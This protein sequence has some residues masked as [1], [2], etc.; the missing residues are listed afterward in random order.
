MSAAPQLSLTNIIDISAVQAAAGVGTYNTSNLCLFTNEAPSASTSA[1]TVATQ[2]VAFSDVAASG[3]FKLNY[4]GNVTASIAY[5]ASASTIQ[6][7][8]QALPGLGSVTVSG[9]IASRSLSVTFVG[10]YGA[11]P[12]LT[13]SS[14]TLE[15]GSSTAITTTVT[16]AVAGQT[17]AAY[18]TPTP[19]GTDFGSASKTA[20]MANAVFAQTPNILQGDGQFIV[21]LLQVATQNISLSGIAASGAFTISYGGNTTASIAWNATTAAIQADL[22]ALPGLASVVVAGSIASQ[23]LNIQFYGVYG[24]LSAVTMPTNTLETSGSVS[25]TPTITTPIVG[26]TLDAAITATTSAF[27]YFGIVT[28]TNLAEM[29]QANMLAA[30]AVVQALNKMVFF[31]TNAS[32][33]I[34]PGGSIDLLRSG[35]Y[36]QSRG[37]YYGDPSEV[38]DINMLAAYASRGLSVNFQGSNTTLSMNLQTLNTIQPDPS[39]SQTLYNYAAASGADLYVSWQG[40]PGVVSNGTNFYFDQVY[41]LQWLVGALQVA[42]FNYLQAVGTKVP[43]T[44]LGM[45]GLKGAYRAVL[46]QAVT[47]GYVAPN[48]WTSA[49]TFGNQA[50]LLANVLQVGFYIYSQPVSQQATA[51]R[52]VRQAPLVQMAIK[53]AGAIQSSNVIVNVNA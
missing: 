23:T 17:F 28:D 49:T 7:D 33:D 51:A 52:A 20:G 12:L 9:S 24:A 1:W 41:N 2:N 22:N 4:A 34:Q 21:C 44:E 40:T 25:I 8:L 46:V 29:G 38:N 10:V 53:Q 6:T 15:N 5:T 45:D 36:T 3:A 37:L 14:N 47:N 48:P 19:V 18:V 43:Q 27:Q 11:P 32:A 50:N 16:T 30:A 26:Q 35:S 42:G 39:M 13:V 31:V